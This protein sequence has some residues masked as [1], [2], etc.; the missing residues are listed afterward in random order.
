MRQS[1]SKKEKLSQASDIRRVLRSHQ[2]CRGGG[3]SVHWKETSAGKGA[4]R[5]GVLVSAKMIRSAAKRNRT[6]RLV[7][8]FFRLNKNQF[9]F[10]GDF[11]IRAYDYKVLKYKEL[12]DIL[13]SVLVRAGIFK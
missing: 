1:F 3:F 6:K 8:E 13:R 11:I 10:A 4:S 12:E 2:H 9:R 5:F 7:R